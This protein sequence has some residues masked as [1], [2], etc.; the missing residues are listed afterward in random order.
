MFIRLENLFPPKECLMCEY[1]DILKH[2]CRKKDSKT[3]PLDKC[4][5]FK[6]DTQAIKTWRRLKKWD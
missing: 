5:N 1:F 3:K 2:Y 6:Y 4:I